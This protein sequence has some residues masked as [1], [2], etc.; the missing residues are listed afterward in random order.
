LA[1]RLLLPLRHAA[2]PPPAVV[3][4]RLRHRRLP[5]TVAAALRCHAIACCCHLTPPRP[6]PM[7]SLSLHRLNSPPPPPLPSTQP[8]LPISLHSSPPDSIPPSLG[9]QMHDEASTPLH[10]VELS[11]E[12]HSLTSPELPDHHRLPH[13]LNSLPRCL[14]AVEIAADDFALASSS[15][16]AARRRSSSVGAPSRLDSGEDAAREHPYA[17]TGEDDSY[18]A[19]SNL[20]GP[21]RLLTDGQKVK[22]LAQSAPSLQSG[23]A[24]SPINR[25]LGKVNFQLSMWR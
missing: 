10:G 14:P 15:C 19:R 11:Q 6:L 4:A 5:I 24:T 20:D 18:P 25:H 2:A 22:G 23:Y 12:L 13:C 7:T 16:S 17:A 8:K 3:V 9:S 1:M 21:D